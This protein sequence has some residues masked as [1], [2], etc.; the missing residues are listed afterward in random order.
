MSKAGARNLNVTPAQRICFEEPPPLDL[1]PIDQSDGS[2]RTLTAKKNVK[3]S[4]RLFV[5][6][7][8]SPNYCGQRLSSERCRTLLLNESLQSPGTYRL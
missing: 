8:F 4:R 1:G 2:N 6:G 5:G 3:A 7:S